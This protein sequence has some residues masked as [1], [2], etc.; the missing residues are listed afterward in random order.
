MSAF[1]GTVEKQTSGLCRV[2]FFFAFLFSFFFKCRRL[3]DTARASSEE[4]LVRG[5]RGRAAAAPEPFGLHNSAIICLFLRPLPLMCARPLH[6]VPRAHTVSMLWAPNTGDCINSDYRGII[7]VCLA[8]KS[9]H[10]R[11]FFFFFFFSGADGQVLVGV[12]PSLI[13]C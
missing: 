1:D 9:A 3:T 2:A 8:I 7:M 10:V 4:P 6:L 12:A 5:H 11:L 13:W